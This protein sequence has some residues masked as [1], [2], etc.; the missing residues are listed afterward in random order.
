MPAPVRFN[1][2]GRLLIDL[3]LPSAFISMTQGLVVPTIPTM[4]GAFG[5][6]AAVAA[7]VVTALV[8]GRA[9][10]TIPSGI[11]IDRLGRKPAMTVGP[12]LLI[13]GSFLSAV[14]PG[15]GGV[16]AGQFLAGAGSALWQLGREVAAVDLIKPEMRGRM[17]ALFFGLQSAGQTLGPLLGGISTDRWGF[18]TVFWAGLAIGL[19]V[20]AMTARLPETGRRG[21]AAKRPLL[22][23]GSPRDLPPEFRVTYLVLIAATFAAGTRNPVVAAILPLHAERA[24]GFS[25]TEVGV[26]FAVMGAVT[27]AAMGPAGWVSDKIGRKAATVPA[28][29]LS[30]VA[31]LLYPYA[32]TLWALIAVSALVG[33]ASGFALGAMTVYTYDIA[34]A[35][36]RGRL[37]ALRRTMNELGGVAGPAAAGGTLSL[38]GTGLAF[39][40]LAPLHL[41]SAALLAVGARETAGKYR[42]RIVV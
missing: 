33:I 24:F 5:V 25:S 38:A 21:A 41:A 1:D 31:F 14:T 35:H 20:L 18:Q 27:L 23:F 42:G 19:L 28:A 17:L 37:Q 39:L 13:A 3:Y 29:L 8:L 4:S 16:L 36:A 32:S 34:P 30:G 6:P 26:L 2:G 40:A 11:L 10:M 22:E 12:A 15:F 7:Q 9:L